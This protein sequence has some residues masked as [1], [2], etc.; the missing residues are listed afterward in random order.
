MVV[1]GNTSRSYS[2]IGGVN[3]DSV[4]YFMESHLMAADVY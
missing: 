2:G 4:Q 3:I 1:P